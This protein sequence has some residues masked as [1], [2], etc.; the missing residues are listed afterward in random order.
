MNQDFN[1][2]KSK[3]LFAHPKR[4]HKESAWNEHVPFAML[5]IELQ[6]P[7]LVVELGTH[8]GVSYCAFC[9]AVAETGV[10]ASCYAVDTWA[11]DAHTGLY[12]GDV[13]ENLKAHHKQY[14]SFSQLLRMTF[15]KALQQVPDGSVDLLHIDGLHTYE[16]V[17]RDY[18]TWLP[19]MSDRGIILFHDTVVTERDYGVHQLWRELTPSSP[20]FNFEH[21]SGLGVL[22]VGKDQPQAIKNFL[23]TANANASTTRELFSSLG[24]RLQGEIVL[25]DKEEEK[26]VLRLKKNAPFA[27]LI[28]RGRRMIRLLREVLLSLRNDPQLTAFSLELLPSVVQGMR[29]GRETTFSSP[30]HTQGVPSEASN[31]LLAY[32]NAHKEGAGIFKWMHYFD[33]YQRHF[34]KFV[35]REV[36]VLEVGIYGGGSLSMWREYFGENCHVYGVDIEPG[37]MAYSDE[38][39]RVFIG[40]QADRAFWAEVKKA[41]PTIDILIDDGGHLPEQQ[42]ITLEEMLPHICS[43]G[44]YL[45]EDIHGANNEFAAYIQGLANGLNFA[46]PAEMP[47]DTAGRASTVTGLQGTIHSIHLYP[48]VAVIEK[49][50]RN[51]DLLIARKHGTQW[52]EQPTD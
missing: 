52:P 11:G 15:D 20:H 2:L 30:R 5:L 1:P 48:F 18:N 25:A 12:G 51:L 3:Q 31:P 9:Q 40:D 50:E 24:R 17:K 7:R 26:R 47:Q 45:C 22:A 27:V 36:H 46:T 21:S 43:G 16:A 8:W 14:E 28:G 33:I 23:Q 35:G 39:T 42:R 37:C 49:R 44:V 41:V 13:Y 10:E 38:K 29:F 19:K 4:L 6:S 32:F 34:H